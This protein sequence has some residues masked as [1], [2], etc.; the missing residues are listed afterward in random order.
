MTCFA[1]CQTRKNQPEFCKY[2]ISAGFSFFPGT[3]KKRS[4]EGSACLY[5]QPPLHIFFQSCPQTAVSGL[6]CNI[7]FHLIE[8]HFIS[9]KCYTLSCTGYRCIQKIP[10]H[11][12][13]RPPKKRNY[14]CRIFTT[15]GFMYCNGICQFQFL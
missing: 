9:H 8:A 13:S 15:L 5:S 1:S 4:V 14:N 6:F 10:V 2:S 7:L 3:R 12:H 11:Q